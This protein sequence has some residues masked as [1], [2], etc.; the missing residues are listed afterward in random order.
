MTIHF[1]ILNICFATVIGLSGFLAVESEQAG[2]H[3][4]YICMG[5]DISTSQASWLKHNTSMLMLWG[6]V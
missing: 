5:L 1:L 4:C 2:V 3:R 6:E